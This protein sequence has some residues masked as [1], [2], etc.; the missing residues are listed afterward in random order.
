[1]RSI[2]GCRWRCCKAALEILALRQQVALLKRPKSTLTQGSD[3]CIVGGGLSSAGAG[4]QAAPGNL[5]AGDGASAGKR[6]GRAA[7]QPVVSSG[8]AELSLGAG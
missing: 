7:S 8:T 2:V 4:S 3:L 5:P 6:F 1:M